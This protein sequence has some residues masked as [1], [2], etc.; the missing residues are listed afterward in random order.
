HDDAPALVG[1]RIPA[2][3]L[4]RERAEI[5]P[6]LVEARAALQPSDDAEI[7]PASS[8]TL[9]GGERPRS[10]DGDLAAAKS[11][12][13]M[14][15]ADDD[16]GLAVERDG[17]IQD[18]LAAAERAHPEA[19]IQDGDEVAGFE[20]FVPEPAAEHRRAAEHLEE[21]LGPRETSETLGGGAPGVV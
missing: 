12:I 8:L 1:V 9:V 3:E 16:V 4:A 11:P 5:R 7:V 6:S 18:A 19:V 14:H 17:L 21:T 20:L 10:E 15:D 13:R 2:L